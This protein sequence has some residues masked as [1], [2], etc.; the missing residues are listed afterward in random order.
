MHKVGRRS[1]FVGRLKYTVRRMRRHGR[2]GSAAIEFAFVAPVLFLFLCGIIE[3]GVLFFASATLQNATDDTARLVRTGQLSG[4]LTAANLKATICGEVA[5]LI[6]A[7]SCNAN[8]QIDLRAYS[9]FSGAS[10]PS[11]TNPNGSLNTGKMTVQATGTCQV[12]LMRSFYPWTI[13]TPLMAPL[14]QN[15]PNGQYLL[16]AASAFRTEPY[17]SGSL[18]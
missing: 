2:S 10:Y 12:V 3:T 8:L 5:N 1:T 9:N 13:M 11:V 4:T 16:A 14:L 17:T 6:S 7:A 15:M 18:C